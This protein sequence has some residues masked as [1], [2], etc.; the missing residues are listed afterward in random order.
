MECPEIALFTHAV[1]YQYWV[2]FLD[3]I[4]TISATDLQDSQRI[5]SHAVM[6]RW[7]ATVFDLTVNS[8]LKNKTPIALMTLIF[9][10]SFSDAGGIKQLLFPTEFG[11]FETIVVSDCP[12]HGLK[13]KHQL[14]WWHS[15]LE[16]VFRTPDW[17]KQLL[18]PTESGWFE[19]IVVSDCPIHCLKIKHQLLWW[20]SF[21]EEVFRTPDGFKQ[22]LFPT[23][24]FLYANGN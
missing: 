1:R 24:R 17:F 21:L 7:S 19:T 6:N 22:W 2:D 3:Q 10:R 11:W 20:H 18:F 14:I 13:I 9:G 8:W 5:D 12:I 4:L 15:F 23:E 16:E